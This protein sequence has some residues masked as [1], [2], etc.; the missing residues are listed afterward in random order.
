MHAVRFRVHSMIDGYIGLPLCIDV[1]AT[2]WN[3]KLRAVR[4]SRYRRL[5]RL[6]IHHSCHINNDSSVRALS[7]YINKCIIVHMR[8]SP[9]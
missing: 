8:V 2:D 7:V 4:R 5:N 3:P 6:D 1:M 9:P